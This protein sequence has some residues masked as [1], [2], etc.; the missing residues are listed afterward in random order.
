MTQKTREIVDSNIEH[1]EKGIISF[2]RENTWM[3]DYI[4]F[5]WGNGYV[6]IP[7]THPLYEKDYNDEECSNLRAHGGVTYSRSEKINGVKYW[8]FGF[9]T[10]HAWDNKDNC[11]EQYVIAETREFAAQLISLHP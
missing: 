10:A 9:D 11:P 3:G 6:A 4:D 5:G 1:H 8:V 2:T 7:E